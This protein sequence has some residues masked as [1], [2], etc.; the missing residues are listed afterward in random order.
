VKNNLIQIVEYG[1]LHCN[2]LYQEK[3][4]KSVYVKEKFFNELKQFVLENKSEGSEFLK[5]SHKKNYGEILQAQQFVGVLQAKDGTTLEIL[6]KITD[7]SENI[8]YNKNLFLKMLTHLKNS[9][10]K[11]I[12]SA[13][14]KSQKI[15]HYSKFS[16][17]YSVKIFQIL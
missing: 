5:I 12:N 10:F 6:P 14:L 13:N 4:S 2:D 3:T 1:F 16:S 15:S 17:H 9:T 8:E 11:N 7:I